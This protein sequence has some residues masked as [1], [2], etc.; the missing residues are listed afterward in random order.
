MHAFI[1]YRFPQKMVIKNT[2]LNTNLLC[3]LKNIAEIIEYG[4]NGFNTYTMEYAINSREISTTMEQK[5]KS[6]I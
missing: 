1:I 3:F 2:F 5:K 4:R 6:S